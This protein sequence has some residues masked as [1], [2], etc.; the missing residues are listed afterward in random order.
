ME[1]EVKWSTEAQLKLNK[2]LEYLEEEWNIEVILNFLNEL[3]KTVKNIAKNPNLG[4]WDSDWD[5]RRILIVEQITMF[6]EIV[7]DTKESSYIQVITLWN[8]RKKPIKK[9]FT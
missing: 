7:E 1:L 6:Y 9:L 5:C 2:N 3:D 8:N 4:R